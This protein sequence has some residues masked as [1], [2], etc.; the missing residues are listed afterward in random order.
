MA[1]SEG[2]QTQ[3]L[4]FNLSSFGSTSA[5][6]AIVLP[7]T[8]NTLEIKRG[9]LKDGTLNKNRQPSALRSGLKTVDGDLKFNLRYSDYDTI[10]SNA[11][12]GTWS[13]NTCISSNVKSYIG[14]TKDFTDVNVYNTYFGLLCDELSIDIKPNA[15]IPVTAKFV[16]KSMTSANT[17]IVTTPVSASGNQP[18][19]SFTGSIKEN[20]VSIATVTGLSISI[21]NS[22]KGSQAVMQ[23]SITGITSGTL[24]V[25]GS[26]DIYLTDNTMLNKFLN[27]TESSIEVTLTDLD[28]H[29]LTI[30]IPKLKYTSGD[31]NAKEGEIIQSLQFVAEYDSVSGTTI[32]FKR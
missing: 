15:L 21:K 20:G 32:S 13:S 22:N 4:I 25:T 26:V 19:D 3:T 23:D 29:S 9:N 7:V 30:K 2:S 16:G 28:G 18:F 1:Y 27:E 10:I 8:E 6:T 11:L 5:N 17:Q 14:V 24:E 12:Q 31:P